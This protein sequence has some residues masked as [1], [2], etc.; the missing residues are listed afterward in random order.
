MFDLKMRVPPHLAQRLVNS[1]VE[2]HSSAVKAAA[3]ESSPK[4]EPRSE[5]KAEPQIKD[6]DAC[7][8]AGFAACV[9]TLGMLSMSQWHRSGAL[10]DIQGMSCAHLALSPLT[11]TC[12]LTFNLRHRKTRAAT[13][14]IAV[15]GCVLG[16][17]GAVGLCHGEASEVRWPRVLVSLGIMLGALQLLLL[18]PKQNVVIAMGGTACTVVVCG[19]TGTAPW[20]PPRLGELCYQSACVPMLW[21]F[22]HAAAVI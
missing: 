13:M 15:L 5:P 16:N 3:A 11:L 9:L 12:M 2:Q 14:G 18:L 22:W 20:I 19:L 7:R 6:N 10:A 8:Y 21:L 17:G 4:A 1:V